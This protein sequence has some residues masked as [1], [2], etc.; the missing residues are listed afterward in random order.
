MARER[1]RESGKYTLVA[2]HVIYICRIL[3]RN[4]YIWR[5]NYYNNYL[6]DITVFILLGYLSMAVFIL[7]YR[8]HSY[9]WAA[10]VPPIELTILSV[11]PQDSHVQEKL[12]IAHSNTFTSIMLLPMCTRKKKWNKKEA[13]TNSS[14]MY[15]YGHPHMAKQKQDDQL[16]HTYSSYVRIRDVNLKTCQKRW[17]IGRS[18]ERGSGISVLAARHD[19]DDDDDTSWS[20][21]FVVVWE[22]ETRKRIKIA[23][24]THNFFSW[25]YYAVLSLRP[26]LVL[27]LLLSRRVLNRRPDEWDAA[28]AGRQVTYWRSHD[29]P[30][31]FWPQ[32]L[33][34]NPSAR[35]GYD[36]RS[37]F[38]RSLTGLNSEFSFS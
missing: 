11:K 21:S 20:Q 35:A 6:E 38:K 29:W 33:F 25:S 24:L 34:T 5:K 26:H 28:P 7:I 37:I 22:T 2:W 1:E 30:Y 12:G 15:S 17:M 36:T 32:V 10:V 31:L 8:S 9:R 16:E 19:D 14:V 18:G 3:T 23:T 13:R 27:P 4:K